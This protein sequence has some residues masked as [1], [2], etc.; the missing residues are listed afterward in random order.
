MLTKLI[1]V[2][3]KIPMLRYV[4][5]GFGADR[6]NVGLSP[7]FYLHGGRF[8]LMVVQDADLRRACYAVRRENGQS[9][10]GK[11]RGG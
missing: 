11:R 5:D 10:H 3:L 7:Y 2:L 1:R 4:D 8:G 9:A 6:Y